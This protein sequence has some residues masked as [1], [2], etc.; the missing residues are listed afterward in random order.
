MVEESEK[1][2]GPGEEE[3]RVHGREGVLVQEVTSHQQGETN[4]RRQRQGMRVVT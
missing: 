1:G 4:V 3:P 2:G